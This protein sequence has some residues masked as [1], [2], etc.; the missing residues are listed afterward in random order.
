MA[1]LPLTI[2][3]RLIAGWQ[4]PLC[5]FGA[6]A[7][8]RLIDS[9]VPLRRTIAID[10]LAMS[11]VSTLVVI[12]MG[13]VFVSVPRPPV[14]QTADQLAALA[15]LGRHT[16]DRDVVLADWRFGNLQPIY[17]DARVF[18][19]H[20]IETISFQEKRAAADRFFE[21][22]TPEAVR[23]ELID[24]WRITLVVASTDRLAL[25]RSQIV[26]QQGPLSIYQITP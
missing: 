24:R 10:A 18:V 14:Y 13:L 17:A 12:G 7:L 8:L 1:Y 3:R 16:T 15:W 23:Q 4:I 9:K 21:P 6:C 2:N 25:P 22:A 5:I 19:G 11:A 20:P 26:F